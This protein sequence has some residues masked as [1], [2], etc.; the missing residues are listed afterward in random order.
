MLFREKLTELRQAAGMTQDALAAASGV[1]LPTVR[2]YE[3]G[4]RVRVPFSAVITL[5][6]ALSVDCLA[7]ASCSDMVGEAA[8]PADEL[9]VKR[10]RT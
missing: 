8:P 5:A 2:K 7:F 10:K 1:P 9:K 6:R 3:Q 4:Q